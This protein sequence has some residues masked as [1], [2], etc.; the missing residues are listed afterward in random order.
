MAAKAALQM[1]LLPVALLA[2]ASLD[3]SVLLE[4]RPDWLLTCRR[5]DPEIDECV[6]RLFQ[7]MFPALAAGIPEIG[8]QPFEPLYIEQLGLT[9][10]QGAITISGSFRDILA[11]GPSNATTTYARFDLKNKVFELGMDIPE[12]RVEADYDLTGKILILPLVGSG[13]ARLRLHNI[14]TSIKC[15]MEFPKVNGR[16]IMY[17]RTMKADFIVR[18]LNVYLGNLFN[19]NK[20][21]GNTL[22]AFLN[23]NSQ[24]VL[25]ELR[26][27]VANSLSEVFRNLMNSAYT[28]IPTDLWLLD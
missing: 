13:D 3:Q 14:T 20:V 10:G 27:P 2:A 26:E 19:G 28:H 8:V 16:E 25:A 21:L 24:E 22:N 5:S 9:K 11:H 6:R 23:K 1:A 17:L 18:G 4:S 12:V 7:H 15:D